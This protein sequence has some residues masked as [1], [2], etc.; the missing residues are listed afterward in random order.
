MALETEHSMV[1]TTGEAP[2]TAAN[3]A[4]SEATSTGS[5]WSAHPGLLA[6]AIGYQ[7]FYS[8]ANFAR[9]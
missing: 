9:A 4:V 3:H 1:R 2:Q 5:F 7:W 6:L 8:G